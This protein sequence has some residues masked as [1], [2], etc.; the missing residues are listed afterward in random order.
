MSEVETAE[1]EVEN[2]VEQEVEAQPEVQPN[3]VS[4]FVDNVVDGS[5]SAAKEDFDN[6]LALKI[7][8]ALDTKKQDIA[9]SLFNQGQEDG[10]SQENDESST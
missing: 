7:T 3:Y 6:V 8:Q 1:V 10:R 9:S 4:N 2:E 5:N